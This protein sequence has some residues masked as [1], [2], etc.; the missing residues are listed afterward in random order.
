MGTATLVASSALMKLEMPGFNPKSNNGL[1]A[2]NYSLVLPRNIP[3]PPLLLSPSLSKLNG[4]TSK[5]WFLML[6]KPLHL[7]R[8]PS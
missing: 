7:L 4:P 3:K 1:M 8:P 5:G 2:L 6:L